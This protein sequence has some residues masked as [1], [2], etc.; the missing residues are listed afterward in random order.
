MKIITLKEAEKN[1]EQ[2]LGYVRKGGIL[3]ID[4]GSS[5]CIYTRAVNKKEITND[6]PG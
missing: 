2:Y 5:L 1:L 3:Y 4:D 6:K